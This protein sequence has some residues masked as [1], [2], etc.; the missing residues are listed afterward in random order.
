MVEHL[1]RWLKASHKVYDIASCHLKFGTKW[2]ADDGPL[3][4]TLVEDIITLLYIVQQFSNWSGIH[5]NVDKCKITAYIHALET[6]LRKLDRE[7]AIQARLVLVALA[8]RSIG[9]L[10]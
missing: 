10:T 8:G 4:T 9:S 6:I 3:V 2:Y 5:L 7:D 1:I